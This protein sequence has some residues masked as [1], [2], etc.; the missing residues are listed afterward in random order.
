MAVSNVG[1]ST[2]NIIVGGGEMGA[3]IRA[4]DWSKTPLGTLESWP[5]SLR[6]AVSILLD[7]YSA[8]YIAWGEQYIQLYNDH[9]R[10]ILGSTKHPAALG[11]SARTTFAESWQLIAPL[12]AQVMEGTAT[13]SEDWLVPLDRHGY[14]EE[15][16]FTY[17]YNPIRVESG[18]VGGILVIVTETTDRFLNDRRLA[19]LRDLAQRVELQQTTQAVFRNAFDTL[20]ENPADIPFAILYSV[21]EAGF[22]FVNSTDL[23]QNVRIAPPFIALNDENLWPLKQVKDMRQAVVIDDVQTRL[24]PFSC[25]LWSE[26]I[27]KAIALPIVQLGQEQVHAVLVIG[28]N[29]RHALDEKYQ[30]FL[31]LVVGQITTAVNKLLAVRDLIAS[32]T[33]QLQVEQLQRDVLQTER[34]AQAAIENIIASI[35]DPFYAVDQ[36]WRFIYVNPSVLE[37]WGKNR[38]DLIGKNIWEVFPPVTAN[39][40]MLHKMLH[41]AVSEQRSLAYEFYSDTYVHGA[42]HWWELNLYPSPTGIAVYFQDVTARKEAERL[43]ER[44]EL[45]LDKLNGGFMIF[46]QNKRYVY[47]NRNAADLALI[48]TKMTREQLLQTTLEASLP[49]IVETRFY[50]ELSRSMAQQT[51]VVFEVFAPIYDLWLEY[52]IY[53]SLD[54]VAVFTVDVTQRKQEEAERAQLDAMLELERQRLENIMATV[55]GVIWENQHTEDLEEM[56][57]VFISAYVETMLG[58][59]VDEALSEPH[60][61]LRI[62]HPEDAAATFD[63][64]YK[65]LKSG[66]SGIVNFRAIHKNGRVIDVQALMITILK[67]DKPVGKRGVMMDVSE[68]QR[69]V[70]AQTRYATM[71]KRSNEELQQFAYVASHDLQE[72]LRMVTSYLQIIESRYADKLDDDARE[73]IG[74]AVDG[75]TR[76]KALITDLLAYSRVE[77]GEKIFEEFDSQLALNKA[78]AN[79]SLVIE[80]SKAIITADAMPRIK[81]DSMQISQ[82]FQNLIGNAIKFQKETVPRIHIGVE[83]KKDEWQFAVRDNGI[84]IAPQYLERIFVIFQRLHKKGEYPGTGIGLAICKKVVER[85]GGRIW[86]ESTV[87]EGTTFFFTIPL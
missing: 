63:A 37:L 53:P 33:A 24:G 8:M 68:R 14:L 66:G 41:K 1:N 12:F 6:T 80:D 77:G 23:A 81:A 51:P 82:L 69:L 38:Q 49:E 54:D 58:Y 65:V 25:G 31:T 15:C 9:F 32:E 47:L 28:I 20:K 40:S 2:D 34:D 27:T 85:H 29:P 19:T 16:Y 56:Q 64:F 59:T 83:R 42:T 30:D 36:D 60:F 13:G 86:V 46:D 18:E 26:P 45:V 3:L 43:R 79:L 71:L 73:F 39:L 4:F 61:W 78:L 70:K 17:T 76:M 7:S 57:L 74:Y 11:L 75:A 62:F 44:M 50:H 55:P 48:S 84:G 87:G 35:S 72:P 22:E 21:T 67:D 10:P 52:R 5:Q